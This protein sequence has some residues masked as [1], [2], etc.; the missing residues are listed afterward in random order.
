MLEIRRAKFGSEKVDVILAQKSSIQAD[1]HQLYSLEV[2]KFSSKRAHEFLQ[3]R[4]LAHWALGPEKIL[5]DHSGRPQFPKGVQASLSHSNSFCA[6][7]SSTE[8]SAIGVD[9]EEEISAEQLEQIEPLI[10]LASESELVRVLGSATLYA[11]LIFSAKESF[12]KCYYE[13]LQR[14]V[15]YREAE[16]VSINLFTKK[17]KL[18]FGQNLISIDY[19]MGDF[20]VLTLAIREK[21]AEFVAKARQAAVDKVSEYYGEPWG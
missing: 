8:V 3:G 17:I 13:D 20:G 5:R 14:F 19:Q 21:G 4:T 18:V 12:Y 1:Y 10:L 2:S 15:D 9:I 7:A 6:L 11:S 16:V